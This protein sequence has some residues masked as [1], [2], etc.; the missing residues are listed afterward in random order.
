[1]SDD[2]V[3]DFDDWDDDD[4]YIDALILMTRHPEVPA[5][6]KHSLNAMDRCDRCGVQA[7]VEVGFEGSSTLLFCSHHYNENSEVL[8]MTQAWVNDERGSL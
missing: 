7:W 1:M 3:E 5:M 8:K 6:A 2:C 4:E